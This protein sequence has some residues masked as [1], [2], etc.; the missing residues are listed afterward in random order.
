MPQDSNFAA[1]TG[2][3]GFL[4]VIDEKWMEDSLSDDGGQ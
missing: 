1:V 2:Y 4:E 3:K